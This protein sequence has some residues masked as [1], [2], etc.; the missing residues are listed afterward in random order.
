MAGSVA[1][2]VAGAVGVVTGCE[3]DGTFADGELL[4]VGKVG[5]VAAGVYALSLGES[6]AFFPQEQRDRTS[7]AAQRTV[8]CFFIFY[9]RSL[10]H[11]YKL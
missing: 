5:D 10:C 2:S 6:S 7:R 1:G 4:S 9:L 3:D 8:I 11:Q